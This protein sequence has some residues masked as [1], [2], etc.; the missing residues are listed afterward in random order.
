MIFIKNY[1]SNLPLLPGVVEIDSAAGNTGNLV[2]V[3][4]VSMHVYILYIY[5]FIIKKKLFIYIYLKN[6]TFLLNRFKSPVLTL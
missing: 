6:N 2:V 5:L 1:L 4:Q 3:T